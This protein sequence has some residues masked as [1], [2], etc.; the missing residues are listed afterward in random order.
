MHDSAERRPPAGHLPFEQLYI[1]LSQGLLQLV[2][3]RP[4]L[5]LSFTTGGRTRKVWSCS[6]RQ[7]AGWDAELCRLYWSQ[8][9]ASTH[10]YLMFY[11][12][13][14]RNAATMHATPISRQHQNNWPDWCIAVLKKACESVEKCQL[15]SC[16]NVSGA[17]CGGTLFLL[18]CKLCWCLWKEPR[19]KVVLL[20][21]IQT[22]SESWSVI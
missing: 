12:P 1:Y 17:F 18:G 6:V 20:V 22:Y 3:N 16:V 19:V 14:W 5:M 8:P 2:D 4:L 13:K 10:V 21:N 11:G 9:P 7:C 15:F